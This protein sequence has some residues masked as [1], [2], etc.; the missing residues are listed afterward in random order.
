MERDGPGRLAGQADHARCAGYIAVVRTAAALAGDEH[1]LEAART[2][3]A[4]AH[5]CV[6]M[7]LADAFRL[8]PGVDAALS[9]GIDRITAAIETDSRPIGDPG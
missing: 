8:G 3:V 7:E 4:W 9:Y 5:G 6:S 1:G 2:V